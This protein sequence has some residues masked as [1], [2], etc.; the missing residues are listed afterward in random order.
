MVITRFHIFVLFIGSVVFMIG[1]LNF[2][3]T[4]RFDRV[5]VIQP[6]AIPEV[7]VEASKK[8][9]EL[10]KMLEELRED[11]KKNNIDMTVLDEIS[12]LIS[13]GD[14]EKAQ[15]KIMEAKEKLN[16]LT[17]KPQQNIYRVKKGDSLWKIS[18]VHY[19]RGARWYDIWIKNKES[20]EDFDLIYPAQEI[21]I[22]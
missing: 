10:S 5:T 11:Y 13:S 2:Y 15:E 1:V 21:V 16:Q 4:K 20:I 8:Q 9:M 17:F 12:V 19:G 22:P 6:P 14:L 18:K 7:D 3:K